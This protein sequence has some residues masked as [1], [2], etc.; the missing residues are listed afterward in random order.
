MKTLVHQQPCVG[1]EILR[2][3]TADSDSPLVHV[4]GATLAAVRAADAE[5]ALELAS[6]SWA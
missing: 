1:V 4:I 6:S 3:M 5:R 2:R